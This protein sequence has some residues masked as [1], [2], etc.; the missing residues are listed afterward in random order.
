[1]NGPRPGE[2]VVVVGTGTDVGK[3]WVSAALLSA[4][5]AAGLRV[6]AR[7]P[8]Q[9][10]EPD[11]GLTDAEVLAAATAEDPETVCP[12]HRWYEVPFAPPMAAEHLGRPPILQAELEAEICWPEPAAHLG[13]VELAGGVASPI[14]S[15]RHAMEMVADIAPDHVLL[16]ADAGLGAIN[17]VRLCVDCIA[18]G[19]GDSTPVVV[20]MNRFD[21]RDEL[22]GR[23]ARWL[24]D[25]DGLEV[26]T[27]S[28]GDTE[29][30][31][32]SLRDRLWHR[33]DSGS[34]GD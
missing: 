10:F 26:V 1:M 11:G 13:L 31:A 22:H 30:V 29:N 23:N 15:D 6:A 27:S 28:S 16:V 34:D 7:K 25:V 17:A 32:R 33:G 14:S 2:L 5:R 4:C 9:S 12:P 8:A 24:E 19:L 21:A 18:K 3:T 20:L